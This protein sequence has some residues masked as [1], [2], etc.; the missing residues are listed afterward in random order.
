[1]KRFLA[2]ILPLFFAT[3][4][5]AQPKPD[6]DTT[7]RRAM[8]AF[9]VPGIAVAIVK[10]GK[11]V[12]TKGYGV[13][14]L[15]DPAPVTTETLFGIASLTKAFTATALAILVDEGKLRWDDRV[16]EHL[17]HFQMYDPYVTREM[18]VR[19]LL[20]HRSGLGLGAGDLL[21]WPESTYTADEIVQRIRHIKP[22]TSFRSAYAYDNILYVV[23]GEVVEAV[24][25]Q[26]WDEFT[27]TRIFAPVGMTASNTTIRQ[28]HPDQE[29]AM[30]HAKADGKLTA[31]KP[32]RID[33]NGPAASINSNITDLA[34]WMLVLLGQGA[35]PGSDKRLFSEKQW[36][37]MITPVTLMPIA[38]P[39]KPLAAMKPNFLTYALGWN[40]RDYRGKKVVM[41]SGGL[42][43][44]T[45]RLLLIPELNL[46]VAVLTNQ[47]AR[48]SDSIAFTVVDR[49]L[50]PPYVD[51]VAAFAANNA[52]AEKEAQE[53]VKKAT[54][55]RKLDTTPSLALD[56]Y[57]GTYR[58]PWYGEVSLTRE[59]GR[60][61][62]RFSRTAGLVGDL[63]HWQHDT[64]IA[65]WRD[66]TLN[67]DAYVT[68]SL[69]PDGSIAVMKMQ[70]VSPLT[71][72]SFDFQDLEFT[73]VK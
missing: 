12:L 16:I 58:D 41:H 68:F 72:F 51:W 31:F 27:R 32:T 67:A 3:T 54:A 19:D 33:N 73:K 55:A 2:I 44:M 64:F 36:K 9:E 70:P 14:K 61:V 4:A 66:R 62:L 56:D 17:P 15:G 40:V 20:V 5:F 59:A 37:E 65:R 29:V 30:P 25:G 43:G 24:S 46:G 49:E 39:R 18:T 22:A 34:K 60:L 11:V 47:E 8:Q 57:A 52:E 28:T 50:G 71:D 23:A 13:R 48:S 45:C 35:L 53:K 1:M 6:L 21:F 69:N 38:E 63:E 42:V 7:V 26:T 10:D